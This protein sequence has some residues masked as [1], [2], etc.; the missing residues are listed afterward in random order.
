VRFVGTEEQGQELQVD[1]VLADPNGDPLSGTVSIESQIAVSLDVTNDF[2]D[3]LEPPRF[4]ERPE[5][6]S[7]LE[8][9]SASGQ[10]DFVFACGPCSAPTGS[11]RESFFRICGEGNSTLP[12]KDV[13]VRSTVTG[14]LFTLHFTSWAVGGGNPGAT[15]LRNTRTVGPV[16]YVASTL[17]GPIDISGLVSGAEHELEIVASDGAGVPAVA[18]VRFV[19]R[20]ELVLRFVTFPDR[21]G[22]GLV[23][24]AET[25]TGV[26]VSRF[27]TGTSPTAADTDGDGVSDGEEVLALRTDPN[28]RDSDGDGRSD[29]QEANVLRCLAR[30][31]VGNVA[32]AAPFCAQA[33]SDDPGNPEANL[34][35]AVSGLIVGVERSAAS[36][37]LAR[38]GVAHRGSSAAVC[39]LSVAPPTSIPAGAP[40]T[41][42]I[43]QALRDEILPLVDGALARLAPIPPEAVIHFDPDNLP[44]CVRLSMLAPVEI[45]FGDVLALRAAL[46]AAA[47][48]IHAAAAYDVDFDLTDAVNNRAT[49]RD[50]FL[51]N[52]LLL[53][54]ISGGRTELGLARVRLDA[55]LMDLVAAIDSIQ[56]ETDPQ[57]DDVLV[58]G[59][60]DQDAVARVR[61]G[62]VNLRTALT[63]VATFAKAPFRLL[64][65]Q[66]LSLGPLLDGDVP[67]L[68]IFVPAFD[69]LGNPD[70]GRFPDPTFGGLAP[71][72]THAE[73]ARLLNKDCRF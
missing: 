19:R 57:A 18:R 72:M 68:R 32:S 35:A 48:A 6:M 59:P 40:S 23:D 58:I 9:S 62:A 34:L 60:S 26:F 54:L 61:L 52:P 27:D 64:R 39:A 47:A 31:R 29:G 16:P 44:P 8:S 10:Q 50:V 53:T 71:D 20:Q 45:D 51:A 67:D 41:A 7:L 42:A 36:E 43:Q 22:D 28:K 49:P 21:D 55:A 1:A 38:F 66:R 33:A 17:P 14:A 37:L 3:V 25:G 46:N 12:G 13:C 56:G 5:G 30:V 70:F 63:G 65:D 4:I 11:F 24:P 69:A 73:L 15:Y 2:R